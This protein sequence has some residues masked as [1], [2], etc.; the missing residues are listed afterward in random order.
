M[1]LIEPFG[2]YKCRIKQ[3]ETYKGSRLK[4]ELK[5]LNGKVFDL[6]PMWMQ[7]EEDPYNGEWAMGDDFA[8]E[9]KRLWD[10]TNGG[11][12]WI[13]SGDVEVLEVL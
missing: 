12:I 5:F 13:S 9:G 6:F 10:V 8:D 4:A 2:R 1:I 3:R 11:L 7:D